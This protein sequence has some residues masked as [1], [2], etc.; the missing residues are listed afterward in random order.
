V[1]WITPI[2]KDDCTDKLSISVINTK[3]GGIIIKSVKSIYNFLR[4]NPKPI[5]EVDAF[6][7]WQPFIFSIGIQEKYMLHA[8]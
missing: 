8:S 3:I 5:Q 7:A 4:I 1:N 6:I 2:I